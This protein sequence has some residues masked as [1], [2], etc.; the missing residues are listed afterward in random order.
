MEIQEY[1]LI[2]DDKIVLIN[3]FKRPELVPTDA[4]WR[5]I[6]EVA[7]E[8]DPE[9]H[10]LGTKTLELR[11]DGS[12]AYVWS[13]VELPPPP[14]PSQIQMWQARAMLIRMGIIDQVNGA[15]AASRDPEIQN[16]WEY[17]P[18]VVRRSAFVLAMAGA[19]GLNDAALDSLFIEGAKIK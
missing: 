18:N 11:P 7:P 3:P 6:G 8:F 16:A 13:V 10:C 9:T 15:V 12:V 5:L 1:A 14:V 19:L 17:A 4:D 2:E